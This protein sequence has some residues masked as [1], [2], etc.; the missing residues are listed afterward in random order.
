MESPPETVAPPSPLA[1]AKSPPPSRGVLV[2]CAAV[3]AVGALLVAHAVLSAR[4]SMQEDEKV[5][6]LDLDDRSP[7]ELEAEKLLHETEQLE[8]EKQRLIRENTAVEERLAALTAKA[9]K[10]P[11]IVTEVQ[12]AE[13]ETFIGLGAGSDDQ[14]AKGFQ[15]A[16]WRGPKAIARVVAEEV[17]PRACACR[18][19]IVREGE[20]IRVGDLAETKLE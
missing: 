2:A 7:A 3:I 9:P 1:A 6:I 10:M 15:F 19:L 5:E 4:R 18:I 13:G 12:S 14:V 16:I 8:A 20:K 17:G 11:L